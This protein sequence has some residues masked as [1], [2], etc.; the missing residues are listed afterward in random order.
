MNNLNIFGRIESVV[1]SAISNIKEKF[2]EENLSAFFDFSA[3]TDFSVGDIEQLNNEFLE[4]QARIKEKIE[5]K[6]T[7]NP[8]E[9]KGIEDSDNPFEKIKKI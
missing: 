2:S 6:E 1:T 4:Y 7:S 9:E 3:K 5:N 8:F